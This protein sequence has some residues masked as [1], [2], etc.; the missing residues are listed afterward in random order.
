VTQYYSEPAAF[1]ARVPAEWEEEFA[2]TLQRIFAGGVHELEGIVA[3]L[4]GSRVKAPDG[5]A[6]TEE[7]FRALL[8]EL[9]RS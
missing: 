6:W 9:G 1:F 5:S 3:A 8:G 2:D 4:N 7:K